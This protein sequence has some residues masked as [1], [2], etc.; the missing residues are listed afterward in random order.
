VQQ[1]QSE[2]MVENVCWSPNEDREEKY[3][4][5]EAGTTS[6]MISRIDQTIETLTLLVQ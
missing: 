3:A 4:V 5:V 6:A 2:C 1:V